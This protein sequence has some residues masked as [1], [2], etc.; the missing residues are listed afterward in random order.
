LAIQPKARLREFFTFC[1][2]LEEHPFVKSHEKGGSFS[3]NV[4]FTQ[5]SARGS[6]SFDEHH[7]ESLL[8]R[9]RQVISPSELF[10]FRFIE[11]ATVK[12][13]GL[14]EET[15][16]L[17]NTFELYLNEPMPSSGIRIEFPDGKDL[18]R[19][20]TFGELLQAELYYGRI[21]SERR[22]SAYKGTIESQLPKIH[23]IAQRHL[24]YELSGRALIFT[25]NI[26]SIRKHI[27]VRARSTSL[28]SLFRELMDFDQQCQAVGE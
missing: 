12:V 16:G 4:R 8:T 10:Y 6:F 20:R 28:T 9:L 11:S 23:P 22:L 5:D 13:F 17:F 1:K 14:H 27:L 19:G 18:V 7:L 3:I 21:H 24:T 15:T 25:E 2:G 26:F